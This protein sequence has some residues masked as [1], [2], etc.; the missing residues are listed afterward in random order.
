MNEFELKKNNQ[1]E[2]KDKSSIGSWDS[3]IVKLCGKVNKRKNYYTTSSCSGRVVLL[4]ESEKKARDLFLFRKHG[5]ISFQE[6]KKALEKTEYKG[7]VYFKQEPCILH[8]ACFS[9]DDAQDLVNKAKLAGW[10][11]SGIMSIKR[12][13]IELLSTEQLSFPIMDNGSIL[14]SDNFLKLVVK[15]SNKKLEKVWKK[16]SRL[17]ELI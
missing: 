4:K 17:K 6:L 7:L 10:K 14:V 5:K 13:M 12:N 11:R 9:L 2:K 16:I 8:V 15:E 1:L 3:K